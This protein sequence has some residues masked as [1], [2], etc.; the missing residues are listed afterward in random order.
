MARRRAPGARARP[1]RS[2]WASSRLSRAPRDALDLFYACERVGRGSLRER[3]PARRRLRSPFRQPDLLRLQLRLPT[4]AGAANPLH[5]EL[6]DRFAPAVRHQ[7]VNARY[8]LPGESEG[9]LRRNA[10]KVRQ[11]IARRFTQSGG[12]SL[13]RQQAEL[14]RGP[15]AELLHDSVLASGSVTSRLFTR[16]GIEGMLSEH[17]RR[18]RDH[19]EVL[20]LLLTLERWQTLRGR[21]PPLRG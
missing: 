18:V 21:I 7:L 6:L 15:L 11:T 13:D 1:D 10:R 17:A 5:R 14:F 2:A 3:H 9:A 12:E 4:G 19:T 20:G 8:I 16:D